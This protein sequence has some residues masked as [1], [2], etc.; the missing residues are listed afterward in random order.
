MWLFV[1]SLVFKMYSDHHWTLECFELHLYPNNHVRVLSLLIHIIFKEKKVIKKKSGLSFI[2]ITLYVQLKMTEIFVI[3]S[4][5]HLV[6][7]L[8][9]TYK[10]NT[11]CLWK[12]LFLDESFHTAQPFF[13]V[14]SF[15]PWYLWMIS[16]FLPLLTLPPRINIA[17]IRQLIYNEYR[18]NL[19]SSLNLDFCQRMDYFFLVLEQGFYPNPVL[20]SR[21][22]TFSYF[23]STPE[24]FVLICFLNELIMCIWL[25]FVAYILHFD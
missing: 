19:I 12:T 2:W 9:T 25:L 10:M 16:S 24:I 4:H 7:T 5:F 18:I 1:N 8:H 11:F 13:W 3:I 20:N 14:W 6:L 15:F 22:N 23:L 21:R 17:V